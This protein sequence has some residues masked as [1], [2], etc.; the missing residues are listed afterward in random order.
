MKLSKSITYWIFA[1]T[2][3]ILISALVFMSVNIYNKNDKIKSLETQISENI[4]KIKNID[5]EKEKAQAEIDRITQEKD[6]IIQEKDGIK[7]QLDAA[8]Q[9][10]QKLERENSTLKKSIEELSIK[11]QNNAAAAQTTSAA[12]GQK[13]CYLT[14]DDGPSENTLRV[15]SILEQYGAKATFFV[16]NTKKTEYIKQIYAAGHTVGLHTSSHDYSQLYSSVDAYFADLTHISNIVESLIGIK[17]NIIRF[18]GGSSNQISQKYCPGI[19]PQ[20]V[21]KVAE[22]G[23]FYFDWNVSSSDATG[24]NVSYT[25][26]RDSVLTASVNKNSIC[27]L[28][29]DTDAKD[30]TVTALP[31]IIVGLSR[32]GYIFMPLTAESY[33]FHH[34]IG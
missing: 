23:Y 26:I 25:K 7:A 29:H 17:S 27:V 11:R 16:T 5:E 32:Q 2:I 9:E 4:D 15:L 28:M 14:F 10:K 19:M 13:I 3:F 6:A 31:E 18:P 20:L 12:N 21:T 24:N 30:T 8:E 33:G 22:Q 34:N 1:I